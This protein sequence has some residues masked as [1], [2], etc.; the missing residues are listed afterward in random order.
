MR[1]GADV[2]GDMVSVSG[3]RR[4]PDELV[5]W[6]FRA[7]DFP[8]GVALLTGTAIVPIPVSPSARATR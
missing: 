4:R 6:L 7:L 1:D 8:V 5:R 3:L 2:Y